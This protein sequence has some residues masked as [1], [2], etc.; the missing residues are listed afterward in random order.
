MESRDCTLCFVLQL[1]LRHGSTSTDK[2]ENLSGKSQ[3]ILNTLEKSRNFS[4][5]TGKVRNFI[6]FFSVIF[7]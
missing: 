3:E 6:Q 1:L 2:K 7:K 5:N 4:Q